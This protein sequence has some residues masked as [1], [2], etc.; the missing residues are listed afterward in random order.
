MAA[1]LNAAVTPNTYGEFYIGDPMSATPADM[2]AF[3]F[4]ITDSQY[5]TEEIKGENKPETT[6]YNVYGVKNGITKTTGNTATFTITQLVAVDPNP[7]SWFSRLRN[8]AQ[9]PMNEKVTAISFLV[10]GIDPATGDVL[11]GDYF[12]DNATMS[13]NNHLDLGKAGD[14]REVEITITEAGNSGRVENID[15]DFIAPL[16]ITCAPTYTLSAGDEP[17][18]SWDLILNAQ[19]SGGTPPYNTI[20]V[21]DTDVEIGTPGE[22]TVK[23]TVTDSSTPVQTATTTSTITITA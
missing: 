12:C 20:T 18:D 17:T 19:V 4:N 11:P 1:G 3:R 16:A 10:R 23:L 8:V 2:S 14:M 9:E 5:L 21:D 13:V 22:Y 7:N 15:G 6:T